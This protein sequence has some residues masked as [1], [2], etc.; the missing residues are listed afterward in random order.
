MSTVLHD[1]GLPEADELLLIGTHDPAEMLRA[2]DLAANELGWDQPVMMFATYRAETGLALLHV[3]LPPP[4]ITVQPWVGVPR[5]AE[6]AWRDPN[7]RADV[8]PL[9]TRKF[10]GW[11]IAFEGWG[12][13]VGPDDPPER[14]A[15]IEHARRTRTN[16]LQPD[17]CEAKFY[18]LAGPDGET[19][20]LCRTRGTGGRP[21]TV[22]AA[23]NASGGFV[24]AAR[25]YADLGARIQTLR[26]GR[27]R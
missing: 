4:Y 12:L 8:A 27:G 25:R 14:R 1:E 9:F 20:Q 3:E 19:W 26:S 18:V 16:Y 24:T 17:R 10:Y 7:I 2:F 15:R 6:A 13:D 11:L 23:D 22:R 21:D 5:Y